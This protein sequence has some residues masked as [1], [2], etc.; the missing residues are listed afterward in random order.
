MT[1]N[2]YHDYCENEYNLVK[3]CLAN[4]P[5]GIYSPKETRDNAIQRL[6]GAGY[7]AQRMGASFEEVEREFYLYKEKIEKICETS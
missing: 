3:N 2:Y 6:L 1:I 7:L 5:Y 4:N